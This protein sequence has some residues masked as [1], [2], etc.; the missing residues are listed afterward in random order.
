MPAREATS[1]PRGMLATSRARLAQKVGAEAI[2]TFALV[3]V[4]CGAIMVDHITGGTVSHVGIGIAFGFT[5][6]VMIYAVGH[7]S[8]AHFNPAVTIA[9]A[10]SGRFAWRQV[11]AYIAGQCVAAIAAALVLYA[12]FGGGPEPSVE[13]SVVLGATSP[14]GSAT[15]S[16]VLEAILTF[17]LM[18]VITSVATDARAVGQMAG[19]AIGATVT[20]AAL[21]GGP[22]SGASMN[23][24]RSLAPA[25]VSLSLDD[26][27]I[28]ALGPI[29]GAI[30]GAWAYR[31]IQCGGDAGTAEGC[32]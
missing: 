19:L 27:W 8:G 4:G 26:L 21:F 18:F 5:I 24:A 7:I 25:L 32:C 29:L 17:F 1:L 6:M 14:A 31:L 11:P 3:F 16:L 28:Y 22:I 15:Q 20:L 2:G 30:A 13:P 9:F 23:P 12:L 10:A